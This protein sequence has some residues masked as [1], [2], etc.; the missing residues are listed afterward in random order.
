MKTALGILGIAIFMALAG[1]G[2]FQ[3]SAGWSGFLGYSSMTAWAKGKRYPSPD[4]WSLA[5]R[6]L[7]NAR[8]FDRANPKVLEDLAF[9]YKW[10]VRYDFPTG[11]AGLAYLQQALDL[12]RQ[13]ARLRPVSAR[14][15]STIAST[16]SQLVQLDDEF[17]RAI[18]N[19][20]RLG[21]WE[22]EVQIALANI[23]FIHWYSLPTPTQATL[24]R[25]MQRGLKRQ[26]EELFNFAT[27]AMRLD[28]LCAAPDARRSKFAVRC[29]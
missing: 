29:R 7:E 23:G 17:F 26:D 13:S 19:A 11:S 24:Q 3:A 16:K 28:V 14:T 4:E 6:H 8:S 22:P 9:V 12:F 5:K 15:W 18:D 2:L 25:V 20:A 1:A 10:Q 27:R 21:P